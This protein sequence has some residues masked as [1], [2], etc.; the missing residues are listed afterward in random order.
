MAAF[1]SAV[2]N[3]FHRFSIPALAP[4]TLNVVWILMLLLVCPY[5]GVTVEQQIFVVAW[6]VIVGGVV[7][8]VI[9]FPS[10]YKLGF[11]F[12]PEL[13]LTD[14]RIYHV[15]SLMAPVAAGSG[16]FQINVVVDSL[17]ALSIESWAPAALSFAELIVHLPLSLIAISLGTVLLPTYSKQAVMLQTDKMAQTLTRSM[18]LFLFLMIPASA[19]LCILAHPITELLYQWHAGK[20]DA[21]SAIQVSRALTWYATGLAFFGA[22][23]IIV[24]AF[25]ALKDTVTPFRVG[26]MCVFLNFCLNVI[27]I[28][29]WQWGYKHAGMAFATV[30]SSMTNCVTLSIILKRRIKHIEWGRVIITGI[31]CLFTAVVAVSVASVVR[32]ELMNYFLKMYQPKPAQLVA[33]LVAA[34]I[35]VVIYGVIS[36]LILRTEL[37]DLL[38]LQ[39]SRKRT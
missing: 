20:F 10:L 23:K 1:C 34:G 21:D 38:S 32:V 30:L 2:L 12:H 28:L 19:G 16:I 27:F 26:A 39:K 13:K 25:Y 4:V 18:R 8:L 22:S 15:I 5:A 33:F 7:E 35:A 24:P 9:Q 17:L 14:N 29:T 6:A 3:S 36:T 31:K 37:V 11:R